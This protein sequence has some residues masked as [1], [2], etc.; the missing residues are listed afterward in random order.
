MKHSS[1]HSRLFIMFMS[2]WFHV[3]C[4]TVLST[5][6]VF[7][8]SYSIPHCHCI[9]TEL[10]SIRL[11]T[12]VFMYWIQVRED[13]FNTTSHQAALFSIRHHIHGRYP[14][15][16]LKHDIVLWTLLHSSI[17][18]FLLSNPL[19]MNFGVHRHG[20]SHL[21]YSGRWTWH[22]PCTVIYRWITY[23]IELNCTTIN[24]TPQ[25]YVSTRRFMI[26]L[27]SNIQCSWIYD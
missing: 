25:L 20:R 17:W 11:R 23:S 19:W 22:W 18:S 21:L 3:S 16:L 5:L 10:Y 7:S 27:S 9:F 13:V 14:H 2:W 6:R 12:T 26:Q 24:I 8:S 15:P 4:S 1:Y